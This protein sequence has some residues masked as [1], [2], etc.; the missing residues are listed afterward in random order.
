MCV[1]TRKN[2]ECETRVYIVTERDSESK[3]CL[4]CDGRD[5]EGKI[6]VCCEVVMQ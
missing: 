6:R 5:S 2:S 4:C 1:L 3:T